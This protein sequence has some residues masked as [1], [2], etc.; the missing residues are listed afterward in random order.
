LSAGEQDVQRL[1]RLLQ[2]NL[3]A[4][5]NS[6]PHQIP[7]LIANAQGILQQLHRMLMAPLEGLVRDIPTLILVPHGS[8]HY[9]PLHALHDGQRYLIEQHEI[10]QLP[11]ASLL[12][13][14][15]RRPILGQGLL[16]FGHSYQGRLPH[17]LREANAIAGLLDGEAVLEEAAT[18]QYLKDS[19]AGRR[20]LHLAVHGDFRPDNP[21]F[22]GLALADGW[23]TTLDIFGLRLNAS[24]ATLSA[25]QTGRHVIGGGDELLGLMRA[26]IYAGAAS[27]VLSLWSVEDRS[28][29]QLMETFYRQLAQGKSKV[30]A[31]RQAQVGFIRSTSELAAQ[32][33][34][35]A[36]PYFWAPFFLVGDPGPL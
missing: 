11:G 26:L 21:L 15:C 22:S 32:S 24:L 16:A 13:F 2:L 4:V 29:A 25:C 7:G 14:C 36:H 6:Q 34:A 9:L 28:T 19:V 35:Y 27:L 31:L 10:T 5:P 23:L 33:H 8:M 20:V 1:S 18:Y 3:R 17:A 30:D 12:R